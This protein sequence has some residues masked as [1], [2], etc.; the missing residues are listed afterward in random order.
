MSTHTDLSPATPQRLVEHAL[1]TTTADDCTVVA[2]APHSANLRW[3]NNTLTTNGVMSASDVTVISFVGAGTGSVSGSATTLEQVSALVEAA[4]AA[5]RSASPAVDAAELVGGRTSP[6]WDD[7]PDSTDIGVFAD[8]APALG[9][10]FG[11]AGDEDRILYG[12]VDHGV[13]TTYL[14]SSRGLRLRHVQPT[15]HYA[16]TA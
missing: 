11:R 2:R 9:E 8:F 3:A 10:A 7:A 12:F 16:C 5:A 15:G 13:V 14:G 4:D 6:D 1:A